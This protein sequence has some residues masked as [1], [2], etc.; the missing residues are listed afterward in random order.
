VA[1]LKKGRR[2][3]TDV[4]SAAIGCVPWLTDRTMYLIGIPSLSARLASAEPGRTQRDVGGSNSLRR[5]QRLTGA[6]EHQVA[7]DGGQLGGGGD[8]VEL[9][10]VLVL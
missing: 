5:Q 4:G 8:H 7:P 1:T 6:G 3:G 2:Y 9:A 10:G